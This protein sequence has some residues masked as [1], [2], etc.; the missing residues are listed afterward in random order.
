MNLNEESVFVDWKDRY[1]HIDQ[2]LEKPG[3]RTD[4]NFSAGDDVSH[5]RNSLK[6]ILKEVV[7]QRFPA[8]TV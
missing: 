3:P 5:T 1:Y 4:P 2:V 7:G 8:K 6:S